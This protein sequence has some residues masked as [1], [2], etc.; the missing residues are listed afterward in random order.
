MSGSAPPP[1]T[2]RGTTDLMLEGRRIEYAAYGAGARS[3][4]FAHGLGD[5][6]AQLLPLSGKITGRRVF[7]HFG[8]HGRSQAAAGPLRYARLANELR[9]VA[10]HT[11]ATRAVGLSMG[12]GAVLTALHE[13][14]HLFHRAVLML[15]ATLDHRGADRPY[16]WFA[17]L[18]EE[19]ER[20]DVPAAAAL[21]RRICPPLPESDTRAWC[22]SRAEVLVAEE[23]ATRLREVGA[24]Y[25]VSDRQALARV[26]APVL[27]VAHRGDLAHSVD[28][29]EQLAGHLSDARLLVLDRMSLFTSGRARV[30][31]ALAEFLN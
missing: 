4:V 8:G 3:T 17:D 19:V 5:T 29:A 31:E 26:T 1:G 2:A 30:R 24:I 16:L 7:F 15:P 6:M 23:F 22:L 10:E 27:V 13:Q 18:A 25:P 14:P 9:G 12:A 11:G 20:G 21:L 28:T